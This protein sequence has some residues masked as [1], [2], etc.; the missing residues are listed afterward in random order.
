M[1]I[2]SVEGF[3]D[4]LFEEDDGFVIVDYKTDRVGESGS[5]DAAAAAYELQL[6]AYAHAIE[7]STG[8]RVS[9]AWLVFSRRALAGAEAGYR[10]PDLD[11]ARQKAL[12][13]AREAVGV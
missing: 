6:G 8:R 4:L 5:L 12:E 1:T 3:I 13:R 9:E 11:T 10:L 2:I 7:A